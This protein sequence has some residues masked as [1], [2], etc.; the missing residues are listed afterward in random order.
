MLAKVD[1]EMRYHMFSAS[2]VT[3]RVRATIY[4]Q[5][6]LRGNTEVYEDDGFEMDG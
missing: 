3:F 6:R 5:S 2:Y 1:D 4:L